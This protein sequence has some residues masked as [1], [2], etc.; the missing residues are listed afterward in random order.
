MTKGTF[1]L[2]SQKWNKNSWPQKKKK[3]DTFSPLWKW[4]GDISY[5]LSRT[6]KQE[7][8]R[9]FWL[10]HERRAGILRTRRSVYVLGLS[11]SVVGLK[12]KAKVK[13]SL[14]LEDHPRT[15]TWL[16]K[17]FRPFGRGITRSRTR[18]FQR[19]PCLL[20]TY[21]LTPPAM[22]RPKYPCLIKQ[23]G[24]FTRPSNKDPVLKRSRIFWLVQFGSHF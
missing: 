15:C 13:N 5:S 2:N 17:T 22:I 21:P 16:S 4:V 8:G 1:F 20:T 19:S 23:A 11:S 9:W 3:H 14:Y 24:L 10:R 12:A 18:T 7:T 6:N